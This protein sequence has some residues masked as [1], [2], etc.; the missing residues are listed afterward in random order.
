MESISLVI[1]GSCISL[2]SALSTIVVKHWLDLLKVRSQLREYP[3][4]IIYDKQIQFIEKIIPLLD[5][6]NGYITEIDVWLGEEGE[7]ARVRIQEAVNN[8]DSVGSFSDILDDYYIYLPS[9]LLAEARN[10]RSLCWE[11][12]QKP[13]T[14]ITYKA[15]NALF[16][17]ENSMR[18]LVGIDSLSADLLKAFG[19]GKKERQRVIKEE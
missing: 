19:T 12:M 14:D 16:G 5:R 11:L 7:D 3:S 15:I 8:S 4:R 17:F 13:T 1:I 6:L 18:K 2:V 9:G 10:L